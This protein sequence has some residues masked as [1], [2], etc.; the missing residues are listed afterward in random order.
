VKVKYHKS[1]PIVV[2]EAIDHCMDTPRNLREDVMKFHV[3]GILFAETKDAWYLASWLFM[4]D[5]NDANNEG[6]MIVK[7]PGAKLTVL[8]HVNNE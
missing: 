2:I 5:I 1:L 6:F 7:T 3:T 8:G 4:K